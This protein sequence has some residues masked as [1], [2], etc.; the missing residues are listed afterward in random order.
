MASDKQREAARENIQ[1]AQNKWREMTPEE[2]AAAQPEGRGREK[3]GEAGG[4]Q[5]YRIVVR[6]KDDFVT[7]RYHDVGESGHIQRLAGKH[8]SGSWDDQAWLIS[9]EDAHVEDN[10]LIAD[11]KDAQEIL[12]TYGPA[13]HVEGDIFKGH[14]RE[15]VPEREKPTKAQ[16]KAR[17]ENIKKAQEARRER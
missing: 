2:H 9:K 16:Q 8:Y 12:D 4:G 17:M 5:Y 6:P 11:T 14:P 10:Q 13:E 3:P 1:K 15:N 7:F